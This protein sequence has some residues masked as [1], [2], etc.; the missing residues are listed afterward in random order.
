MFPE[1]KPRPGM[2]SFYAGMYPELAEIGLKLLRSMEVSDVTLTSL[3][4]PGKRT[5]VHLESSLKTLLHNLL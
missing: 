1:S 3:R 5:T 2:A 4:S